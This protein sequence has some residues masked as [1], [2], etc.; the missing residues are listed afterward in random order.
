M[1]SGENK[2]YEIAFLISSEEDLPVLMKYLSSYQ[3][4][5]LGEGPITRIRLA[6][7]IKKHDEAYFS[8]LQFK[9]PPES[10]IKLAD[11]LKLDPKII[12]FIIVS[13]I[14]KKKRIGEPRRVESRPRLE[15]KPVEEAPEVEIS[16]EALEKK[17]E[18]ILG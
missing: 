17:L 3:A 18:E 2:T 12:R 10:V 14:P 15:E 4:E 1:L 9:L 13:V 11:A 8:F 6:Y 5:I 7:T 16:N